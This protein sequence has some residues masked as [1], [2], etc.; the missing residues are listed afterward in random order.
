M[1]AKY[2]YFPSVLNSRDNHG[3]KRTH[4]VNVSKM[5]MTGVPHNLVR[6]FLATK[7]TLRTVKDSRK[8]TTITENCKNDLILH[9]I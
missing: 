2:F 8:Y 4:V 1:K 6:V 5:N 3:L 7:T 9:P